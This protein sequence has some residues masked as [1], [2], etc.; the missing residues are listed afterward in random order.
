MKSKHTFVVLAYKESMHLEKCLN[1]VLNQ[2]YP[3]NVIIATST[4][5][6]FIHKLAKKYNL[7]IVIK[8]SP[9]NIGDDFDFALNSGE[10]ELVT[11][12]HQDD[13]YDQ[14]Y[15]KKIVERYKKNPNGS[16]Y[17]TNYYE[18]KGE[19]KE[20]K[21]INLIIKNILLFPVKIF[22]KY[23]FFRRFS[24]CFGCSICCPS[25][26]FKKSVIKTP[27]FKTNLKC[28]ID[29]NA[30]EKLS[31]ENYSFEYIS[32][33]LMGHRVHSESTTTKIIEDNVR[34]KEDLI[35]FKKFWPDFL[36]KLIN[37]IYKNSENNNFK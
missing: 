27:L 20:T 22:G 3:S 19:K 26:T 15:S 30:W 36:A 33:R 34:T 11:I 24:L 1:S 25:V 2:K 13:I 6:N 5:N 23:K 35:I 12:A 37:K 29:W 10:T 32:Q 28:D 9:S 14:D 4:P 16:I 31:K 7:P 17:F 8:K 18:I 21:N